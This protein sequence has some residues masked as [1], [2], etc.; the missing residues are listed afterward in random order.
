MIGHSRNRQSPTGAAITADSRERLRLL[1]YGTLI[2]LG[3]T[4]LVFA[5]RALG[6]V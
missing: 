5:S 3:A 4:V 6:L 1:G 2:A